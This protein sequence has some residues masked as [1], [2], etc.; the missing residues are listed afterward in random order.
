MLF[1]YWHFSLVSCLFTIP[2]IQRN[3][4]NKTVFQISSSSWFRKC[5]NILKKVIFWW[6][7]A[8]KTHSES[9]NLSTFLFKKVAWICIWLYTS[10]KKFHWL[11]SKVVFVTIYLKKQLIWALMRLLFQK[12]YSYESKT[13]TIM[14]II[15]VEMFKLDFA[16]LLLSHCVRGAPQHLPNQEC[17]G[18]MSSIKSTN[19]NMKSFLDK[20][21]LEYARR[22]SAPCFRWAFTSYIVA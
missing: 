19:S 2:K 15:I 9:R 20:F 8:K 14:W 10:L 3:K 22:L 12:L 11:V 6:N 13:V 17:W 7:F 21:W 1:Q 18:M 16:F 5:K 4:K